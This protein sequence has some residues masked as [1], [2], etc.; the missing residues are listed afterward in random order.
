MEPKKCLLA[1]GMCFLTAS[2]GG[3]TDSEQGD[4]E[5]LAEGENT[6]VASQTVNVAGNGCTSIGDSTW[7]KRVIQM[8]ALPY[9]GQLVFFAFKPDGTTFT[10]SGPAQ[11]HCVDSNSVDHLM[12]SGSVKVGAKSVNFTPVIWS[13]GIRYCEVTYSALGGGWAW[14][15]WI[16]ANP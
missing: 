8:C 6:G 13:N 11:V 14:D 5:T 1:A 3:S 9:N 2:C 7:H 16:T 4:A 12:A 10:S 15:G